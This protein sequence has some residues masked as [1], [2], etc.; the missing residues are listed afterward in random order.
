MNN[1]TQKINNLLNEWRHWLIYGTKKEDEDTDY[2]IY[3]FYKMID[4]SMYQELFILRL[5][6]LNR[7]QNDSA[8]TFFY[9]LNKKNL[10]PCFYKAR[11][12]FLLELNRCLNE[13]YEGIQYAS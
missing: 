4:Q 2:I 3:V 13:K 10:L 12:F 9:R 11:D 7:S 8:E 5:F 6:F 1:N